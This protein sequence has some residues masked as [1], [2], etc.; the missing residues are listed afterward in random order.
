MPKQVK[1]PLLFALVL[2]S[3]SQT[4]MICENHQHL[5][6]LKFYLTKG[7]KL[8]QL[9]QI[10]IR[11]TSLTS[12]LRFDIDWNNSVCAILVKHKE[13]ATKELL[14]K[15]ESNTTLDFCGLLNFVV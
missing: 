1:S 4:L 11:I 8:Q 13:F 6:S 9:S 10:L 12:H 7:M 3:L 14:K 5:K 2:L 15:F